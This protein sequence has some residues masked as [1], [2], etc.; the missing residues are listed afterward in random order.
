MRAHS[1]ASRQMPKPDLQGPVHRP[2]SCFL[3][4][5]PIASYHLER[6]RERLGRPRLLSPDCLPQSPR[7]YLANPPALPGLGLQPPPPSNPRPRN[8]LI[9]CLGKRGK[10]SVTH[11]PC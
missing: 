4:S 9:S 10:V 11:S 7:S 6:G 3:G 2:S 8:V 5:R 1:A